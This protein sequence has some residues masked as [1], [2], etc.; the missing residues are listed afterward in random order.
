MSLPHRSSTLAPA[1]QRPYKTATSLFSVEELRSVT[2]NT[3]RDFVLRRRPSYGT[4]VASRE[5][6]YNLDFP[7]DKDELARLLLDPESRFYARPR[8]R[9]L[10]LPEMLPYATETPREHARFLAHIVAHLYIAVKTLDILG[11]LAVSS[12][13]L[14]ALR[15]FS[16]LSD[17]DVA[18]ETNMFELGDS[19]AVS[20]A[21]TADY[22]DTD[23][24]DDPCGVNDDAEVNY[25]D[26]EASDSDTDDADGLEACDIMETGESATQHRKEPKSA[27]GVGVRVW[28]QELLVWLKMKYDMPVSLRISLAK[29]YYAIACSRGQILNP[30]AFIKM[31]EILTKNPGFL[32]RQGLTLPWEP[33]YDEVSV[34]FPLADSTKEPLESKD[35]AQLIR[36][37]ERASAFFEPAA[38]P[39]L[40]RKLGAQF[41]ILNA[42]AVLWAMRLLPQT[43]SDDSGTG[44]N[45][46]LD[47]RYYI[48]PLFY[49]W[50]KLSKSGGVDTHLPT[51]LGRTAMCY[52]TFLDGKPKSLGMSKFGVFSEDQFVYLI[53]TLLNSLS[54]NP[55][56]FALM[57][58]KFFHGYASAVV[59]SMNGART[60]EPSGILFH[61]QN[62]INAIESFVH[63]S[64]TGE[65]SKPIL[66]LT[67]SLVY[68]F[69]KRYN[70]E[71]EKDGE[72]C[73]LP[74]SVRLSDEVVHQFVRSMLGIV[75]TGL[76]SKSTSVMEQY[77]VALEFL[78][79]LDREQTLSC[80]L[81]DIY[82]SL[83]GVISTH[84]VV[85]AMRCMEQL[86][87]YVA[88]T[89]WFRVHLPRILS[90]LLPGIDLNDLGKT[91]HALNIFA[92]AANY[93]P[94]ADLTTGDGDPRLAMD[95]TNS[96]LEHLEQQRVARSDAPF[97]VDA[98]LEAQ[99][100]RSSSASFKFLIRSFA[101]RV[102]TLLENIP[103]PSKSTGAEKEL[104][105][106]LPKLVL[107]MF[108]AM[109][110]DIFA[111]F[112]AELETF[113]LDKVIHSVA[114]EVAEI[115]GGVV[116]RDPAYFLKIAPV[117]IARIREEITENGAGKGRSGSEVIPRDQ[118]LFWY[119]TI[120]NEA[121]GNAGELIVDMGDELT[122]LSLF[123]MDNVKGRVAFSTT[124]LL[125][126][127]LQ[128]AT[129]IRLRESRLI[130]P[131]Y[132]A[133]LPLDERC[134]GAFQF[135]EYRFSRE[136]LTFAWYVPTA[137]E[138]D[139]AV[140]TFKTHVT[141]AL[142]NILRVLRAAQDADNKQIFD[143]S[144]ELRP[145]ILYLGFGLSGIA[146]LLDPSFDDDIPK[147]RDRA[148]EP[149]Q[150][151]LRLLQQIREMRLKKWR[152]DDLAPDAVP[153]N[154]DQIVRDIGLFDA[155]HLDEPQHANNELQQSESISRVPDIRVESNDSL[156]L[157]GAP[158]H[159]LRMTE[160]GSRALL[161]QN[162]PQH[163]AVDAVNPVITFR[164]RKLYTSRY[165]F[166]DDIE[167]RRANDTYLEVHRL[168]HLVG[169][170]LHYI[171]SFMTAHHA[172]DIKVFKHLLYALNVWVNDVGKERNLDHCHA[173]IPYSY[174]N[175]LQQINRVRK[176]FLRITF[177][178]RVESYH[179]FRTSLHA[180]LRT[181]SALDRLLI[182][183]VTRL[184][185]STYVTVCE[186]AQ[187]TLL[188]V[189]K[190]VNGAYGVV[191]R[192]ALTLLARA[193]HDNNHRRVE[194][195]LRLFDL[196]KIGLRL[197]A[198]YLLLNRF[199][200][201]LQACLAVDDEEVADVAHAIYKDFC[202]TVSYPRTCCVLE[203]SLVDQIRPPDEHIDLEIKAVVVAKEKKRRLYVDELERLQRAVATY[204]AANGHWKT[205]FY[206]LMFLIELQAEY[207]Q[208]TSDAVFALVSRAVIA[209]HPLIAK[210]AL[211]GVTKL[212]NKVRTLAV[213][214]Y[215]VANA[216]N[217][218]HRTRGQ[219]V[220][221]TRPRD[222][223][224]Y[225][226]RWAE[227]V[228]STR[229]EYFWDNKLHCG[230]LFWD[231]SMVVV[232][233]RDDERMLLQDGDARVMD[234]FSAAIDKP[235]FVRVVR[236]WIDDN[237]AQAALHGAD[238]S[239]TVALV[240]LMH[241]DRLPNLSF[242]DLLDVVRLVY[243]ADDKSCHI[244]VCE[245]ISGI[246]AALR[247][248]RHEW[249]DARDAFLRDFLPRLLAHDITPE[250]RHVWNILFWYV[251]GHADCRRYPVLQDT[252]L[253][254]P[255]C[256]QSDL[257]VAQAT[258]LM[259]LRALAS[260]V[261]WGLPKAEAI[262][263][264]CF[265]HF[266]S[267]YQAVRDQAGLLLAVVSFT[268]Y[269]DSYG[270]ADAF[271]AA[272]HDPVA[273]R[274]RCTNDAFF[275]H[276]EDAFAAIDKLH[277][278]VRDLPAQEILHSEYF[279][280]AT[281]MLSYLAQAL[282]T[283]IAV[284]LQGMVAA[285]IVPFLLQLVGMKE[286]CLLGAVQP[287]AVLKQ[288]SQIAFEANALERVIG[289][290]E[291]Y[292]KQDLMLMQSLAMGEFV[293]VVYFK[294]LFTLTCAQRRRILAIVSS[295]FYHKSVEIREALAV[296]FSGLI[297][298]T[299]PS[300]IEAVIDLFRCTLSAELD[301]VRRA[302]RD[303]GL[304]NISQA[305]TVV[306][307]GATLGLG[308]L[309]H[310]FSLTSP[311]PA[312]IPRIL[313]ILSSKASGIPGLVGKAA[314]ETLERFKKTRQDTWH[315]DSRV[316]SEAQME[317]L[318]GVL[319]KSYFI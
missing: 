296:T 128:G 30:K 61:I 183:D 274:V 223:V 3:A 123:L 125:N 124:H 305:D 40:F 26:S 117:F 271:V 17:V 132:L 238:V 263:D 175:E 219:M 80:V 44:K 105:E 237:D 188:D 37:A 235:W 295:M 193:L 59:F 31:F 113:V 190:R 130:S 36:L 8:P 221:D 34:H 244:V 170:S 55:G 161:A 194:S 111:T 203:H 243:D 52:L 280:Y 261:L 222:G 15:D 131:H 230:W 98:D 229:P 94:Y 197:S 71:R 88:G 167:T 200:Q 312:W 81:P 205:S 107:M 1:P 142:L 318:E 226:V 84:R 53:N 231:D 16:G 150:N 184:A 101:A 253:A 87:R 38:L 114:D 41:S 289:M 137:R 110:D 311:P 292:C 118:A 254:S 174:D 149:L 215:C 201:L 10:N 66:K 241:E 89:V 250:T 259:Y 129:E 319:W 187:S 314:K 100:V 158:L 307:H 154:L 293:E 211:K 146:F 181:M 242:A 300:E 265:Q 67:L 165:F 268:Y 139:F 192:H 7:D 20:G 172:D 151:R 18:L 109:S 216:Y 126:Q 257:A 82:E 112:R 4:L 160:S 134:W 102:F 294:N 70:M 232:D 22:D 74:E 43:F 272:C 191:V 178:S 49:I 64:N 317:A 177:G 77:L 251:P 29:V 245:L 199:M 267:R 35:M 138:V 145:A 86:V 270:D 227:Q 283:S 153:A 304:R 195:A 208:P 207:E 27:S 249:V 290:F 286:V 65:W 136:N 119:V 97:C 233:A 108:E 262:V 56:K 176:P 224:S 173:R 189:L 234:A 122:A 277:C 228:A 50:R 69:L 236:L 275:A 209:H 58:T 258:V 83:D 73:R 247:W 95:F 186:P 303:T 140:K 196:K 155:V 116:K 79:H 68:Q 120:L 299:P 313:T 51:E 210:L 240:M 316:F 47:I 163:A 309:V 92:A 76:Q 45:D 96:H 5:A 106:S 57:K 213:N 298:A 264:V 185:C 12:K 143:F 103:D 217:V 310:A 278:A 301:R 287:H 266:G 104:C 218:H 297:H 281:A 159:A 23:D 2:P 39:V 19:G 141:L 204:E 255:A 164:D 115:L 171:C 256:D 182:Q 315:I 288:V 279:Y 72:L 85:T 308:A 91:T 306:L 269:G 28:T 75:R 273:M 302:Y 135:D 42:A 252:L 162:S 54:I 46:P 168:R 48:A 21:D 148:A 220:V 6:C 14:A 285:Q 78:A 166:G 32:R 225:A 276:L 13:D 11:V 127:M 206:N 25:A 248:T 63:P 246:L 24:T 144:D 93:V 179:L 284:Q 180:A 169:Q 214:D 260:A 282:S 121:V 198:D 147:L 152:R 133:H 156:P 212:L 62:L 99:A 157:N 60:L 90:L 239:F 202:S 9:S 33:L 291:Y